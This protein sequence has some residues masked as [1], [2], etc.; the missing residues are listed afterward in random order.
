MQDKLNE[1]EKEI[2]ELSTQL[3]DMLEVAFYFAGLKKEHFKNAIEIY[4]NGIDDY[5]AN[6]E[7]GE[8]GVEEIIEV[9]KHIKKTKPQLFD[10]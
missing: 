4:L 5:Y 10:S 6:N 2:E 7:D 8:M 1:A 3:V 9:I